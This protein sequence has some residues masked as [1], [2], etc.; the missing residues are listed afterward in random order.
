MTKT[1][2]KR[3]YKQSPLF[4]LVEQERQLLGSVSDDARAFV[5]EYARQCLFTE[6]SVDELLQEI[7]A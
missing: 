2:F 1:N 7:H 3:I 4:Q 5:Q 6:M